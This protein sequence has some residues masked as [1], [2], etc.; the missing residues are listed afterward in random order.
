[1][2]S[3]RSL[4]SFLLY[5][6]LLL[7]CTDFCD[8]S[9]DVIKYPT[10]AHHFYKDIDSVI[11]GDHFDSLR[12]G[13]TVKL[14][15]PSELYC[16]FLQTDSICNV[17]GWFSYDYCSRFIGVSLVAEFFLNG[18]TISARQQVILVDLFNDVVGG[19]SAI[20]SIQNK[21]KVLNVENMDTIIRSSAFK[22]DT[23]Q[24]TESLSWRLARSSDLEMTYFSVIYKKRAEP[25]Q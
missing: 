14:D 18:D 9:K 22:L 25:I 7:G 2:L 1:M 12:F 8:E 17:D 3:M 5:G 11:L 10:G 21:I 19:H 4:G 13:S 24:Y 15:E 20:H 6:I 23:K 16:Q